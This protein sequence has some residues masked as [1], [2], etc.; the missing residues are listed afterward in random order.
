M[1][2]TMRNYLDSLRELYPQA[3]LEIEEEVNPATFGV[4]AI[5]RSLEM[6][7]KY[8]LVYFTH[9]FSLKGEVSKFPLATNVFATRERCALAMGLDPRQSKLPL[10][11]EYAAREARRLPPEVV[12]RERAPVK[13]IVRE[14]D[15]ADLRQFPIV[16]H[17]EMD[18]GPYIDMI[19]IMRDPDIGAY[20]AAFLR[21]MYKGPRKLGLHMSPRHNWEIVRKNEGLDR[22]TPV[23]IVVGHHPSFSLAALNVVP[24]YDDDY[25][26]IGSVMGEPLRVTPSETWGDRFMVPADAEI[27]IEGEVVPH[28]REV[29]APF[30]EF[31]GYYG[32]QRY[33]WVIEV[34]AITTRRGAIYQDLF[35]GHR[36]NWVLGA[37][38][39]EGSVYNRIKAIV[40]TVKSVCLPNSGCGRF[41]CYISIDKK[42]D[43][44]SKQAA[45]IALGEIDFIKNVVVV[46]EDVDPFNEEEVMWSVATRVQADED[47][48]ILKNVKGN[49]LDPSLKGNILTAKMIIDATRPVERPFAARVQVPADALEGAQ[50]LLQRRGIIRD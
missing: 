35:V 36:D 23:V 44:D 22:A 34:K 47:V 24:F 21:T 46:D 25:E 31:T 13:E 8:P 7:G 33:R 41:N 16:R 29:E 1:L 49:V 28:V 50:S 9:P 15:D 39:K 5:L 27:L 42:T 48:D 38:P 26:V 2:M 4:T 12:P 17:H 37:I 20:N 6:A 32:P 40:P 43:G 19:L 30:G 14:G 18:L 10:S 11:L 3:V 45:L